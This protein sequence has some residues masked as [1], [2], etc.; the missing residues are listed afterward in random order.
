MIHE[1]EPPLSVHL[2]QSSPLFLSISLNRVTD[3]GRS[4][5][6]SPPFHPES[7]PPLTKNPITDLPS[8]M[9]FLVVIEV[10]IIRLQRLIETFH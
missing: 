2:P 6:P 9:G 8:A 1:S 5:H 3:F 7:S 10:L 4:L